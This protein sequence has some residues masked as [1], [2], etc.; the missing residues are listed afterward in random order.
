MK[1][2]F[3]VDGRNLGWRVCVYIGCGY[4]FCLLWLRLKW[5]G[6]FVSGFRVRES[7]R[8]IFGVIGIGI[9]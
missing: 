5:V 3:V 1:D 2:W 7:E 4:F 6:V 9:C 8:V